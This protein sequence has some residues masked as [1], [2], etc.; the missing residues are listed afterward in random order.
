MTE[1]TIIV[2]MR[3]ASSA[4]APVDYEAIAEIL[5]NTEVFLNSNLPLYRI[6]I[7]EFEEKGQ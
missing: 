2:T 1:K 5:V 7:N 4:N 6:H 3:I